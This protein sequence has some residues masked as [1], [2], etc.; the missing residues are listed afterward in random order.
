MR[1]GY[2]LLAIL[3][4]GVLLIGCGNIAKTPQR[5]N[6]ATN[7]KNIIKVEAGTSNIVIPEIKTVTITATG[8]CTLAASQTHSYSGSF[9]AY[10]D[11]YG[12]TYFFEKV[13][14]VFEADDIT[15]INL[16]CVFSD[17][18][19]RTE[20]AFNFKGDLSYTGI[21]T[22]S[23]VEACTLGNNHIIDYGTEGEEDTMQ[24]L[25]D[26]NIAYAYNDTV[27]YYT[28]EEGLVVAV[29]SARV[30]ASTMSHEVYLHDGVAEAKEKGADL[31][32]ACCHWGIEGD[33]Y[34]TDFQ[35]E[36]AHELIDEGADLIIGHHPHVLQGVEE[37]KG[38]I[39]LY[40]LGNFSF[41][42]NLNPSDKNTAM[43]QQTF[44]FIGGILT[45]DID[46]KIYPC[47]LSGH[48]GYND[49][50]PMIAEGETAASILSKM[51]QYSAPYGDLRFAE[52]GTLIL[53]EE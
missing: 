14:H 18:T 5:I 52:D 42:G 15:L 47:R 17:A 35:Q 9:N 34:P 25:T 41:G 28:T 3:L 22:S 29:V 31:V 50:Q 53:T 13:K 44:T 30:T 46:A 1:K 27:A 26:A 6:T 11:T 49:F 12:E 4:T 43:Y 20:K 8:D 7:L 33:Y 45:T 23:S 21:L 48:S 39:I 38:K 19:A 2:K 37:Y 36:L 40:S 16:E 10:Y 24:A 32:I 51:K